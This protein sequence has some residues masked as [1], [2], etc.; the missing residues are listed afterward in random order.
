MER[1]HR[2]FFSFNQDKLFLDL[3]IKKDL[4]TTL[5]HTV[6]LADRAISN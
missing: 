6:M 4:P 5:A 1:P 2:D 3:H